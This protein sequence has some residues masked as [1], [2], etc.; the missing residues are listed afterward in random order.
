MEVGGYGIKEIIKTTGGDLITGNPD[1]KV[2]G[3]STDTRTLSRGDLFDGH[4]FLEEALMKGAAG[5]IVFK[6]VKSL[7]LKVESEKVIIK[8]KDTLQVLGDIAKIYREKFTK[9]KVIAVTGSNGKTT[10]K[11]MLSHILSK[12]FKTV[13]AKAS[14]NN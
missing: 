10:T 3:I 12:E 7:K 2:R 6:E 9:I 1:L 8:V 11:E 5:A 13:K 4:Y 14:F